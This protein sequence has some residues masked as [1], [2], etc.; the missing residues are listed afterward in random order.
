MT[1][2]QI[3][4]EVSSKKFQEIKDFLSTVAINDVNWNGARWDL[5]SDNLVRER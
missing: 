3:A 4:Y 1:T 5:R 2:V